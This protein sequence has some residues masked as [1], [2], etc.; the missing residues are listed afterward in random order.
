MD[1]LLVLKDADIALTIKKCAFFTNLIYYLS[2]IS[3]PFRLEVTNHTA[4]PFRELKKPT[5]VTELRSSV[6]LCN[7]FRRFV[8]SFKSI[9]LLLPKL[10]KRRKTKDLGPLK[11]NER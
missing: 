7:G 2:Y 3:R 8:P 9:A 11:E 4:D 1:V 6:G 10:P 5:T